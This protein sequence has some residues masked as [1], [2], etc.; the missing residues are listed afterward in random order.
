MISR[1][2][3]N[4]LHRRPLAAAVAVG[5]LLRLLA[6]FTGYGWFAPDDYEFGVQ[7]AGIWLQDPQAAFPCDFRSP[8]MSRLFWALMWVPARLGVTDRA[9]LLQCAY[10]ALG[11]L[12]VSA[13]VAVYQLATPLGR[14]ASV[15]AAWLTA[16][17]ALMPRISTRA[18]I[19]V[20]AIVPLSWGVVALQRARTRGGL[21]AGVGAGLGM[22]LATL[23]RFQMGVVFAAAAA[24]L[25][26]DAWR[27][28]TNRS[29]AA[30][31]EHA[32]RAHGRA[33][34]RA[35]FGVALGGA[36]MAALQGVMDL[37][38][39]RPFL[40]TPW[41]Y[42]A[43]NLE[44]AH[45]YGTSPWYTYLLHFV[46]FTL[47]PVTLWL[48]RPMGRALRAHSTVAVVLGVFVATH[49]VIGHK[50]DRFM[51]P[52]LPLFFVPLGAALVSL[53]EG[54]PWQRRASR[55]FVAV[56][57]LAL[58]ITTCSDAHRNIAAPLLEASRL[59]QARVAMVGFGRVPTYYAG[60]AQLRMFQTLE[61]LEQAAHQKGARFER[62]LFNY[63][64][65]AAVA[66]RVQALPHMHCAAPQ[67]CRG[68][69]VDRVLVRVNRHNATR[70][71]T[72]LFRCNVQE[73]AAVAG[74]RG[75]EPGTT[76]F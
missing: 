25:L 76:A 53:W 48:L 16:T 62:V 54:T 31:G 44:H 39:G 56:N 55:A 2:F 3:T 40:A 61:A 15:A 50:E 37:T 35:L 68:D 8:L 19:E 65:D 1:V 74:Y 75:I 23:L 10:A 67:L 47:P 30:L 51:F 18:M 72:A 7:Q 14:R 43:F 60:T 69:L 9:T 41:R 64:P 71:P 58:A 22:G 34:L 38:M 46:A 24:L 73:E 59:P 52:M 13:I 70:G 63:P 17:Y 42:I 49:S 26:Y 4:L 36:C 29:H 5:A 28:S 12:S 57:A 21:W 33:R 11:L 66:Q 6:A 20:I 27:A 45:T 32:W